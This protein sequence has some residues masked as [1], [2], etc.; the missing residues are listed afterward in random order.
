MAKM[1]HK[2]TVQT[3]LPTIVII[4]IIIIIIIITK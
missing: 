2:L 4:I 1:G 3:Y